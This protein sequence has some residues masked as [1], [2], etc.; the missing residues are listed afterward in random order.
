MKTLIV[1]YSFTQNNEKLA[2]HL[3]SALNCDMV[4]IETITKRT[5]LSIF[6][7]LILNRKPA[8]KTVPYNLPEYDHIIFIAPIWAGKIAMPLKTFLFKEKGRIKKYSFVTLCGGGDERQK[9]KIENQLKEM[10]GMPPDK[11]TEL[12]IS[13]L[14]PSQKRN[15]IKSVTGYRISSLEFA[16]F[17]DQIHEVLEQNYIVGK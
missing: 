1:Y 10:T 15:T 6:L 4:R 9:K 16:K 3:Q 11:V 12:W 14:L 8:I 5:G 7:D 2:K 13:N 17:H